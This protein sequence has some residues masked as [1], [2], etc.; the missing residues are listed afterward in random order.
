MIRLLGER[1][2]GKQIVKP[3]GRYSAF[4]KAAFGTL[5][6]RPVAVSGGW[7]NTVWLWDPVHG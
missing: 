2:A 7:D 3:L 6:G 5:D 1:L 4:F